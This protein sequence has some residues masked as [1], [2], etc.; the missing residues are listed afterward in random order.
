[1]FKSIRRAFKM[2]RQ[3]RELDKIQKEIPQWGKEMRAHLRA[4]NEEFDRDMRKLAQEHR[5]KL[6]TPE[7]DAAVDRV[8]NR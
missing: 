4:K 3:N 5:A 1:M 8:L 2:A 6:Q 7:L